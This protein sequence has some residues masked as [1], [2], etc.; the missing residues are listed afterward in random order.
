MIID[1]H[2][3]FWDP[4]AADYPWLTAELAPIRRAFGPGDLEPLLR[5][6]EI[7]GTVVVQAN[8][9]LDETRQLLEIAAATPFVLGVVGWI[10][11]T[12]PDV[13]RMLA[14]L[15][16][17]L[18]GIRHQVHDEADPAW[19]LR[20]D[21]QRGIAAAGAAGLVFDLLVRVPQLPAAFET[22]RRHP[23]V[24]FVVDHLGK[25]AV[26][27]RSTDDWSAALA[28]LADLPNVV[29]KLSGLVTEADWDS[30]RE[31]ELEPYYRRALAWFGA[32]RCMFGSDWPVCLLAADY[33][34]VLALL[35]HAIDDLP[36]DERVR[37]L[38]D[39]AARTYGL[40]PPS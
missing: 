40:R 16:G 14:D 36:E 8:A 25:P 6:H 15:D 29:C 12:A 38:G 30:W 27:A 13:D 34:S 32:D 2:Q 1:A 37:V 3:H 24:R 31:A 17:K 26:R 19:L 35:L 18:V 21:V 39:T 20:D 10:D 33:G 7:A 23:D 9:T 28:S 22:A 4:K 5:E 11:L